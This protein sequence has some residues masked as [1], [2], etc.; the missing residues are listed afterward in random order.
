MIFSEE[1]SRAI[2][3]MGNLELIELTSLGD[4]SVSFSPETRTRG[5]EHVSMRRP[6]LRPNQSTDGPNQSNICSVENSIL[7]YSSNSVTREKART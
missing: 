4:Y 5:I 2:F 3:E 6:W 1:S 7:S